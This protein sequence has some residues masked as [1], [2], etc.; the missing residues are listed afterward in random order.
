MLLP[1]LK[2]NI[3]THKAVIDYTQLFSAQADF[4]FTAN[5]TSASSHT[6]FHISPTSTTN[7]SA[8]TA[9][10][11]SGTG[12]G[13]TATVQSYVPNTNNVTLVSP[14]FQPTSPDATSVVEFTQYNSYKDIML[15]GIPANHIIVGV[16]IVTLSSFSAG[17]LDGNPNS[18]FVFVGDSSAF[19]INPTSTEQTLVNN[20]NN[21]YGMSN[22]TIPSG[23]GDSYQ[24]GSFRWFTF[25]GPGTTTY[26]YSRTSNQLG[27]PSS[28]LGSYCVPTRLD[29]RDIT[30]RFCILDYQ[31]WVATY[32]G[33]DFAAHNQARLESEWNFNNNVTSG[34]VEITV[35]YMSL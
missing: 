21:T 29:A 10:I 27:S 23:S 16:K 34:Q 9:T 11:T 32:P 14:G 3:W 24:Y 19:P 26:P 7:M 2:G 6:A 35:Q 13:E 31:D 12:L 28:T 17:S 1:T 33:N 20:L 15:F 8:M 5:V 18:V 30:A 22:L 25:S 4:S